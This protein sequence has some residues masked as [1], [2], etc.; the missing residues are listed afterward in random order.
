MPQM[1][2]K[3]LTGAIILII[4]APFLYTE[5]RAQDEQSNLK[6]NEIASFVSLTRN[7]ADSI[8][9][10]FADSVWKEGIENLTKT[11]STPHSLK[12]NDSAK[13][14]L[15]QDSQFVKFKM[16]KS[17][18]MAVLLS[19]VIPGAGQ[20]YNRS[21]WK[22]PIIAGLVGYFGYEYI[23]NNNKFKDYRDQYNATITPQNEFGDLNLKSLR[24][25]YRNQRNDFVW[26][27]M[28]VYVV[29]LVDAYVDAHLFDF[30]VKD[31]NYTSLGKPNRT[32]RL[33]MNI[34]F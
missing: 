12:R 29:N 33:K 10:P 26:Y 32:Y 24:E 22:I 9:Q 19:A 20:F 16:K 4:I 25:F 18:A 5:L 2:N 8:P 13:T 17:P 7:S 31:N 6:I 30:D 28:I 14:S 15:K 3:F 34:R 23:R 27:F 1:K 11:E 21:Y